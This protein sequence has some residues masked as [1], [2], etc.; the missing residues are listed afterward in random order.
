MADAFVKP[1]LV[2]PERCYESSF[3]TIFFTDP[4]VPEA[5]FQVDE[6][7]ITIAGRPLNLIH[8]V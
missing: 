1:K 3:L 2:N 6:A 8:N 4:N 5:I 7:V